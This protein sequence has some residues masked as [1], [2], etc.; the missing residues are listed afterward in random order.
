MDFEK[1]TSQCQK[2]NVSVHLI[3]EIL[4]C[5]QYNHPKM[6][7][8]FWKEKNGFDTQASNFKCF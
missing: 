5:E 6:M 2:N 4:S 3:S 8:Y 1:L 7:G